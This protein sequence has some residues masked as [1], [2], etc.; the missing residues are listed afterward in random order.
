MSTPSLNHELR[1][2]V[3]ARLDEIERVLLDAS[4][5]YQERH[6]ILSDVEAHVFEA[7]A[8]AGQQ[9]T[10]D[11]LQSV[12]D[13]LDPAEAYIPEELRGKPALLNAEATSQAARTAVPPRQKPRV[14]RLA[15]MCTVLA[16]FAL[17]GYVTCLST[18]G[19][20]SQMT[21]YERTLMVSCV[22]GVVAFL[23]IRFS[24]G[25]LCGSWYAL[26]AALL[27]PVIW[28]ELSFTQS[29]KGPLH[30][31]EM[32]HTVPWIT[33]TV[34]NVVFFGLLIRGLQRLWINL[35]FRFERLQQLRRLLTGGY[36]P[37]KRLPVSSPTIPT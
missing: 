15:V 3:D 26:F 11:Q 8:S 1:S 5:S 10:R 13:A 25:R 4:V 37:G 9:P 14:S 2:L 32:P 17:L 23:R 35:S 16:A 6:H 30:W 22:C 18:P 7:L 24:E 29:P 36:S 20:A 34:T 12:L 21:F 19:P 31:F 33:L 28:I 27:L